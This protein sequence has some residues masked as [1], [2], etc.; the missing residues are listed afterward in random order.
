MGE[1]IVGQTRMAAVRR[2][3]SGKECLVK[4]ALSLALFIRRRKRRKRSRN[5]M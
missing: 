1:G 4:R 2:N 5:D 3:E